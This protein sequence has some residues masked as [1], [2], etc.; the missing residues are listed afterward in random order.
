M[1]IKLNFH[2][3]CLLEY[4]HESPKQHFSIC[5]SNWN[6]VIPKFSF[7]YETLKT[8]FLEIAVNIDSR[9]SSTS[10]LALKIHL[11]MSDLSTS[12]FWKHFQK[13]CHPF[14]V[15]HW[16]IDSTKMLKTGIIGVIE[17]YSNISFAKITGCNSSIKLLP[18]NSSPLLEE[19]S[20][21]LS[22]FFLLELE[23]RWNKKRQ[24]VRLVKN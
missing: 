19:F 21:R 11:L 9:F 20:I 12:N 22:S 23:A 15:L 18:I 14:G 6:W 13:N 8:E 24:K 1:L 5:W 2:I 4:F 10:T 3:E 17:R 16:N 7:A